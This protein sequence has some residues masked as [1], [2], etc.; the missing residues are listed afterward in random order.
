MMIPWKV[1]WIIGCAITSLGAAVFLSMA[2]VP[3]LLGTALFA[4]A[5]AVFALGARTVV[6]HSDM[7][8]RVEDRNQ[9]QI[10]SWIAG[11]AAVHVVW[12]TLYLFRPT[13][14]LTW[15]FAL[16]IVAALEYAVARLNEYMLTQIVPA[17]AA[18]EQQRQLVAAAAA[19]PPEADPVTRFRKGLTRVGRDYLEVLDHREITGGHDGRRV[20]W[21]FT[22]QIPAQVLAAERGKKDSAKSKLDGGDIE[23]MA[24]AMGPSFGIQLHTNWLTITKQPQAGVYAVTITT[25]DVLAQVIPFV[26]TPEQ[27]SISERYIDGYDVDASPHFAR[28]DQHGADSG[29]SRMGKS[30][31]INAK[32]AHVTRCRDATL[33]VCGV[34]KLYDGL[35]GWLEPYMQHGKIPGREREFKHP[36]GWIAAGAHDA[37]VMLVTAFAIARWRQD[38]P[39]SARKDFITII[40]Q[41]DEAAYALPL[42]HVRFE[43]EGVDYTLSLIV[44]DLLFGAGSADVY[45][46]LASQRMTDPNL[47]KYTTDIN[48]NLSWRTIFR[49]GDQGEI[50]RTT[51]DWGLPNPEH[52]GEFW[53]QPGPGDPIIK[54]KAPYMQEIDPKKPH[55]HDGP[56]ISDVAWARRHFHVEL[57]EGSAA[58][59]RK[60]A[61]ALWTQRHEY[62]DD[63]LHAYMTGNH[64]PTELTPFQ[65]AKQQMLA[66][67]A[68]IRASAPWAQEQGATG[69]A[70]TSEV[71]PVHGGVATLTGRRTLKDRIV[72]VVEASPKPLALAEIHA[73]A[74]DGSSKGT[75]MN[76]L[77]AL[78][79]DGQLVRAEDS[80]YKTAI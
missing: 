43:Y 35:A 40:V 24:I 3:L 58:V 64:R 25:E 18:R 9:R 41:I 69:E 29:L 73:A 20:G 71:Q 34:V 2:N 63:A 66:D 21:R 33:W 14:W 42:G 49:T 11:G 67:L 4:G 50:G 77:T 52:K 48:S 61:G 27:T 56:T 7:F 8:E 47:G 16:A 13:M 80:T 70:G 54:L 75:V 68:A 59:A 44:K 78:V 32:I 22:V 72:G 30:S 26:D 19:A 46:H 28:A 36:F 12:G 60:V 55:L 23:P 1:F 31:R 10:I 79:N 45:A 15:S 74:G 38:Q 6:S 37:L 17:Q 65:E 39:M 57:D 62:A 51:G 53:S 5:G 76:A